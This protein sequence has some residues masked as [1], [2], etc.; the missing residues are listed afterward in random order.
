MLQRPP[1]ANASTAGG[2]TPPQ[3]DTTA[4]EAGDGAMAWLGGGLSIALWGCAT[5]LALYFT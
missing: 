2:W 1:F 3:P 4:L 5:A